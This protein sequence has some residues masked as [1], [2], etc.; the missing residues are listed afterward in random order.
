MFFETA[1]PPMEHDLQQGF[2]L[3]GVSAAVRC[4]ML[5]K[6][7]LLKKIWSKKIKG[8]QKIGYKRFGQNWVS[9]G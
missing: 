2:L 4:E 7:I 6:Q 9:N 5:V 8:H 1:T 3:S